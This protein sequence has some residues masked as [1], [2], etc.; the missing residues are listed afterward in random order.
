MKVAREKIGDENGTDSLAIYHA[1]ESGY[2]D[3]AWQSGTAME[4]L[5][6]HGAQPETG[7]HAAMEFCAIAFVLSKAVLGILKVKL[8]HQ[9]ITMHFGQ[10]RS[11]GDAGMLLIALD[12]GFRQSLQR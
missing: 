12:D 10:N 8:V 9:S 1:R 5:A 4:R 3:I 6:V 11:S 2:A 7:D